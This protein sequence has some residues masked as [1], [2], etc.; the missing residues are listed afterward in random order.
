MQREFHE[1]L[2]K[3]HSKKSSDINKMK[4]LLFQ[5][6]SYRRKTITSASKMF[7]E[8][9]EEFPYF[10]QNLL[11]EDEFS[12]ILEKKVSLVSNEIAMILNS[13]WSYYSIS[14]KDMLNGSIDVIKRLEKD[15]K[16]KNIKMESIIY[17][18]KRL[19]SN[20]IAAPRIFFQS[21]KFSIVY[22]NI[23]LFTDQF[24]NF[25]SVLTALFSFYFI[26]DLKYPE[27][28]SQVLGLLNSKIFPFEDVVFNKSVKVE[29]ILAFLKA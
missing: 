10:D 16:V 15:I 26:Y 4:K 24:A 20:Q 13:L 22:E 14:S 1:E 3:Q 7:N 5:S 19:D 6:Y 28:F 17:D 18:A 25:E 21:K 11:R 9:L 8:L 12:T 23:I 27:V 2:K 29:P